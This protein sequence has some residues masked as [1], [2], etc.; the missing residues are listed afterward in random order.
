M[1]AGVCGGLGVYYGVD[2]TVI[3]LLFVFFA[4][5]VGFSVLLYIILLFIIPL[6]PEAGEALEEVPADEGE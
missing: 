1:L 2:P 5:F 3:R 4:L 6:E